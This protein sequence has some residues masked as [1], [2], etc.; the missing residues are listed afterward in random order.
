MHGHIH[1]QL[2][3]QVTLD[4]K[5]CH[6]LLLK[7]LGVPMCLQVYTVELNWSSKVHIDRYRDRVSECSIRIV[8]IVSGLGIGKV[9]RGHQAFVVALGDHDRLLE[10]YLDFLGALAHVFH[11][12]ALGQLVVSKAGFLL[13]ACECFG[14][15]LSIV[16]TD[17]SNV[18][19]IILSLSQ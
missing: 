14:I 7:I 19:I 10:A 3:L 1:H 12:D 4:I 9:G 17:S 13:Y 15:G 6:Y 16:F 8:L 18:F 2:I 5:R 11:H